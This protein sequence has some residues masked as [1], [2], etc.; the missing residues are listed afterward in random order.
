MTGNIDALFELWSK[1]QYF[2][3]ETRDELDLI[4]GD[5]R[6][7][8]ERFYKYLEFGTG[9]LRGI[10]GAGTNRM[11]IYTVAHATE[12]FAAYLDGPQ[13]IGRDR[14]VVVS[15]DSRKFSKEFA[16]VTALVFAT[17]GIKVLLSDMLRPTPMLS[18]AVRYFGALG[19]VM[20]TASHNPAKYNGYKAYGEDGGQMPPEA[21]SVILDAM[22]SI[23]DIR[24]VKWICEEEA[25][26]AGD[27]K[28]VV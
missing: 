6:E 4:R 25:F 11:N 17:H 8:T 2:D 28:S 15:Y 10:I 23:K 24:T 14:K 5:E 9:G 18:F 12:G 27:R 16:M 20:I 21:A 26:A 13:F 22:H 7:I 19:G 1:D 3:T